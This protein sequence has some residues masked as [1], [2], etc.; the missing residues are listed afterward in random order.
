MAHWMRRTDS[1]TIIIER[2]DAALL[3]CGQFGEDVPYLL[4]VGLGI[5][6]GVGV[7]DG[8]V[9]ADHKGIAPH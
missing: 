7:E 2:F 3:L 8:S 4:A 6:G 1:I 9:F 5:D